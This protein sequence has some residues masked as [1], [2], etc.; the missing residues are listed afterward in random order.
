MGLHRGIKPWDYTEGLKL[1]A[2]IVGLLVGLYCGIKLEK[3]AMTFLFC[4]S[5][6]TF[7]LSVGKAEGL[8]FVC[9]RYILASSWIM[10]LGENVRA[11]TEKA[12]YATIWLPGA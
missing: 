12:L 7:C 9:H 4:F 3:V 1:R 10:E 8:S 6:S 2:Y 5:N 11:L